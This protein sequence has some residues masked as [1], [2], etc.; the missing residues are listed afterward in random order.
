MIKYAIDL[1]GIINARELG[2]RAVNGKYIKK[3]VLLRTGSTANASP[4]A[5][6]ILH[7]KYRVRKVIDLRMGNERKNTPDISISDCENIHLPVMEIRDLDLPDDDIARAEA[8]LNSPQTDRTELFQTAY[9]S[10]M[11]SPELYVN[12][13][14]NERGKKAYREFFN[15]LLEN[16]PDNGAVL[17]HC[18][19]GKDRTGC[20][21]MLILSAL[22]ADRDTIMEDYL[23]TNVQ[24]APMLD[25]VRQKVSALPMPKEKLDA[26]LFM[27]GG[28]SE[29]YMS[30]TIDTLDKKYGSVTG[31]LNDELGIGTAETD[32]L[33][34]KYLCE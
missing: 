9:Q 20:G 16:E 11:L 8:I 29:E 27:C 10:G 7:D 19:D 17:W 33:C 18:T 21:A 25:A 4:K 13:L 14:M 24:C 30:H 3:G 28:V 15:I 23:L 26:L 31:Y 34:E 6:R 32:I 1:P 22:G 5:V 2:G 12:F